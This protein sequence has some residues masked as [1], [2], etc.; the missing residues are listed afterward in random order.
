[1]ETTYYIYKII[2]KDENVLDFYVGST[3]SVRHRKYQHKSNCN[4]E[5][6]SYN[7]KIYQ[8]I[9]ENGGWENWDLKVIEEI[10]NCSK[11]QAH[12]REEQLRVEL[13]ATLNSNK[14]IIEMDRKEYKKEWSSQNADK[15]KEQKKEYYQQNKEKI[16]LQ[17]KKYQIQNK[18]KVDLQKKEYYQLN[19]NKI[20]EQVKEYYDSNKEKI[21]DYKKEVVNCVCGCSITKGN[22]LRHT[23]TKKHTD[24]LGKI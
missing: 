19:A 12:I 14:V 22:L 16:D 7:F 11:V 5:N 9:R 10:S 23:K 1:M 8:S 6:K 3:T 17:N 18:E 4:N 24:Y 21:K 20:K 13:Q 2:C 15:L